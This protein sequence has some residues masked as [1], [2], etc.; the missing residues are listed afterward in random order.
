M[1]YFCL[2]LWYPHYALITDISTPILT[3]CATAQNLNCGWH[4]PVEVR[5]CS[6]FSRC[7]DKRHEHD[8]ILNPVAGTRSKKI[9][10]IGNPYS[11]PRMTPILTQQTQQSSAHYPSYVPVVS[12][13]QP[14]GHGPEKHQAIIGNLGFA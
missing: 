13:K 14:R 1:F 11:R 9:I 6:H 10:L 4:S 8:G 7:Y 5:R 2:S 3:P 12:C